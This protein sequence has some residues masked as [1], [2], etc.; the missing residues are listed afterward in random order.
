MTPNL[1]HYQLEAARAARRHLERLHRETR[2]ALTLA[3]LSA[4]RSHHQARRVDAL[5]TNY[6]LC[7]GVDASIDE[8]E[9]IIEHH[10]EI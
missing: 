6:R 10:L 1:T 8:A 5:I 9:S 2:V 3:W 7:G 4:N